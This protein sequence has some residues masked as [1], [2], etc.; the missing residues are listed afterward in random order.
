[1]LLILDDSILSLFISTDYF[2]SNIVENNS[3]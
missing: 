2:E 3:H 1:M